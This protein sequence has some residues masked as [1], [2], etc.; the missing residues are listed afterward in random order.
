MEN[1]KLVTW[2]NEG[3][4]DFVDCFI[5]PTDQ[6]ELFQ[7]EL[8]E[9]GATDIRVYKIIQVKICY[10]LFRKDQK[11]FYFTGFLRGQKFAID[12]L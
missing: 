10:G 12:L 2:R 8:T 7:K 9:E 11:R 3:R 1:M 6:V 4:E 5:S